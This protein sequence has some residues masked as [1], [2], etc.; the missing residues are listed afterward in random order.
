MEAFGCGALRGKP[1]VARSAGAGSGGRAAAVRAAAAICLEARPGIHRAALGKRRLAQE[2]ADRP[3][4]RRRE[5]Q[6][7]F[8]LE[9]AANKPQV[10]KVIDQLDKEISETQAALVVA[11]ARVP[12]AA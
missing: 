12:D 5:A 4:R 10:Q 9:I 7:S 6:N 3:K 1:V 2:Q 8:R 11:S